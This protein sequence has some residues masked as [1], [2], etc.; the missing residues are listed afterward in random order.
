MKFEIWVREYQIDITIKPVHRMP[1]L[2]NADVLEAGRPYVDRIGEYVG[3]HRVVGGQQVSYVRNSWANAA[4]T[5]L[6]A[7]HRHLI[8]LRSILAKLYTTAQ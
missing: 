7:L 3:V 2:N 6:G 4:A 8:T 1:S 5:A